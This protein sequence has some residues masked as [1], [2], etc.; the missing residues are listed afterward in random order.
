[1][2]KAEFDLLWRPA[3]KKMGG[4]NFEHSMLLARLLGIDYS[5]CMDWKNSVCMDWKNIVLTDNLKHKLEMIISIHGPTII[6]ILE[7]RNGEPAR[8]G[9][10]NE[11]R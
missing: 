1:M 2:T 8:E 9:V 3:R 11:F 7:I 4:N 10:S 6:K 5:V